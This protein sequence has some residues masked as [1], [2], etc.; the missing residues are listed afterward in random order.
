VQMRAE[1]STYIA[2]H[3]AEFSPELIAA[4]EQVH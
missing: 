3:Q 4:M 2:S 1:L